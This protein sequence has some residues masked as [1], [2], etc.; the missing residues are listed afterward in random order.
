MW[1]TSVCCRRFGNPVLHSILNFLSSQSDRNQIVVEWKY[2]EYFAL[3]DRS[4]VDGFANTAA[5]LQGD[6]GISARFLSCI[7]HAIGNQ[8]TKI[9][10]LCAHI[11]ANAV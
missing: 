8:V 1:E 6:Y 4:F 5:V 7:K 2:A 10:F 3:C 11:I 9:S